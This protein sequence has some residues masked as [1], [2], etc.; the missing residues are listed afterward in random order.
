MIEKLG[1]RT[2]ARHALIGGAA[3]AWSLSCG[4][5]P[6]PAAAPPATATTTPSPTLI[7]AADAA[8]PAEPSHVVGI[9]RWRNPNTTFETIYR[10]TGIRLQ[11]GELAA[12]FL[13]SALAGALA[14]DAP[15]DAVAALDPKNTTE[16]P[17]MAVSV[18]VR[19]LDAARRAFQTMGPI[20]EV[21]PG[22]FRVSVRQGKKKSDKPSCLLLSARGSAPGR[23]ICG[24]RD[25]DVDAL[26]GYMSRTLPERD[27]GTSDVHLELHAPPVVDVYAPMINQGLNVGAAL[28]RRKLELGEPTFD[29][30]LGVTATGLSEEIRAVLADLDTLTVDLTVA[31][32]RAN[33]SVAFRLKGQQS[34][35]AGTLASEA[36]RAAAAPAMFW[37]LPAT[38]ISASYAYPPEHQRFDAIRHTLGE[39]LDGYLAHEGL[40]PADRAPLAAIF[41]D[42]Y[43]HDSP[44]VTASGRFERDGATKPAAKTGAAPPADPLQAAIDGFGWYLAG[45]ATPN[46]TPDF[47]KTLATA[48]SRPKLQALVRTKLAEFLPSDEASDNPPLLPSGFTFKPAQAPKE[49]PKGSSAFELAI[50][51]ESPKSSN[52][53]KKPPPKVP[54]PVKLQVLVVPE[55]ART[56][57]ILGSDKAQLVKT[58]LAA[59]EAAPPAGKLSSRADLATLKDGKYAGAS[60]NTL[61]SFL[62]SWLGGV[63]RMPFDPDKMRM[64]NETRTAL[65][66]TPNR[67][68]TPILFTNNVTLENGVT[69]RGSFDVPKGVIEDAI[70]LAA[71]SRLML[72]TP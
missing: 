41:D 52:A 7:A 32:E 51:R 26:R 60:F 29:R 55:S 64:L 62:E 46:Q 9:V 6:P 68:K 33:A 42:K 45:I 47:V 63:A 21:R 31:P 38:A 10:W 13:D 66:S 34:W 56:W 53:T 72:P 1:V 2:V 59:T 14:F 39:L 8:E 40:A 61:Q 70:V 16:M 36:P 5:A 50:T 44:W 71:S 22:E 30:A 43:S 4:G 58:V 20:T 25:H 18:G 35:V 11:G 3:A 37:S 24:R 69:W 54:A 19:S 67:G 12:Q 15:V 49:L 23:V 28:A 27:L 65:E 17:L 57:V 48:L